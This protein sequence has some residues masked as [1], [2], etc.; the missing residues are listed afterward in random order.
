MEEL[1][2]H[3]NEQHN[4]LSRSTPV[5]E[6]DCNFSARESCQ[7]VTLVITLFV[8]PKNS[9]MSAMAMLRHLSI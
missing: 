2:P 5:S 1:R 8:R 3:D 9:M 6:H 4:R 7:Q